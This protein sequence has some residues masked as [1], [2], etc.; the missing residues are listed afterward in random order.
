MMGNDPMIGSEPNTTD[1]QT[2]IYT[3]QSLGR[4]YTRYGTPDFLSIIIWAARTTQSLL[5]VTTL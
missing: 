3:H 4:K 2:T 5:T 1:G